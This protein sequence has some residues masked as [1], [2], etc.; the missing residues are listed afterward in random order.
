MI[1]WPP[2]TLVRQHFE[3]TI[4][5]RCVGGLSGL[6]WT[7]RSRSRAAMGSAITLGSLRSCSACARSNG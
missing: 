5:Y 4:V 3:P 2:A 1:L 6:S 7:S